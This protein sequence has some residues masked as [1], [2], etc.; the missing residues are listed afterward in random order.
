[1]KTQSSKAL[2]K[3]LAQW[4]Q[5]ILSGQ[6]KLP[7]FQRYEA[8]DKGRI[9]SFLN[10]VI[11]NLPIGVA[12]ILDVAGTEKFVSRFISTAEPQSSGATV[13]QHLLDGQQRLTA[14]WRAMHNNYKHEKYFIYFPEFDK[15]ESNKGESIEVYCESR[16][17]N[18]NG[19]IMPLWA[20]NPRESFKRG[21]VPVE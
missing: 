13:N 18:K 17:L 19:L 21:L 5:E 14:F 2:N 8:W 6:I 9:I 3:E 10:T 11:N 20:D 12:L 7:R 16:W 1:M 4:Y 15:Y